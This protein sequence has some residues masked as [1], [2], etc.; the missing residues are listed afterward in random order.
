MRLGMIGFGG[1]AQGAHLGGWMTRRRN[2]KAVDLTIYDIDPAKR[3]QARSRGAGTVVDSLDQLLEAVDVVDICTPSDT[4]ADL[5]RDRRPRRQ[6][7]HQ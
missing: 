7:R 6:A 2:G 5:V 3:E 1:I 4:H